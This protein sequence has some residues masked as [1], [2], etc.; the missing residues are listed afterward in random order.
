MATKN[1]QGTGVSIVAP[2]LPTAPPEYNKGYLDKF[3]NILRLYFNQIDNALRNAVAT[4]VPYNLRVSQGSVVGATALYKFGTNSDINGTEETI[5]TE[6]GN[7]PWPISAAL[8]YV[9]STS[10]DDAFPSG[11]GA[12]TIR[13]LGLDTDYNEIEEDIE[14]N[15]QTQV[16]TTKQYLRVYRAFVLTSGSGGTAAGIIYIGTSGATAGVP[17]VV[18]ANLSEGNQTQIALYTVPAGKTLY[19]DDIIF[20]TAIS[21]ANSFATVKFNTR[22]FGS[23]TF[24]TLVIQ[25]IQSNANLTPFVYPL[26]IPEKTDI[27]C[28]AFTTSTNNAIS[29]AFQGVLIDN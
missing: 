9:S 8:V 3:N 14:L 18:Y 10:A 25:N 4:A 27:E 17:A 5:W 7:Y 28:R 11:T 15:G 23:N 26:R 16:A 6:G 22:E 13:V 29:A 12:R 2:A 1:Q 19:L 24:R 21:Q 20:T